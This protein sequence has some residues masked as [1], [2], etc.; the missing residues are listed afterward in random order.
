MTDVQTKAILVLDSKWFW[1]ERGHRN[2]GLS[3]RVEFR[4]GT[5]NLLVIRSIDSAVNGQ[6][7]SD[8]RV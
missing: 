4:S 8:S 2:G 6:A 1:R 3:A 7:L 5:V